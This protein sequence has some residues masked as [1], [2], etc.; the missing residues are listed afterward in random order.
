[1]AVGDLKPNE[2]HDPDKLTILGNHTFGQLIDYACTIFDSNHRTFVFMFVLMSDT[3][4]IARLDHD[5][6][7]FSDLIHWRTESYLADFFWRLAHFNAAERG[8]DTSAL[9]LAHDS[10]IT[11]Q[12]METARRCWAATVPSGIDID[13]VF[14][15]TKPLVM[16]RVWHDPQVGDD[17]SRMSKT[18]SS[19][20][21]AG[22]HHSLV[23]YKPRTPR[24][25]V[26]GRYTRGYIAVDLDEDQLVW[27]KDTWRISLDSIPEE[28]KTYRLLHT[29][30]V[31]RDFLPGFLFGGDVHV[32]PASADHVVQAS[33]TYHF[34]QKHP[35][36]VPGE[37]PKR[38]LSIEPH[39][40][41]RI[42]FKKIGRELHKFT[43]TKDLCQTVR[44]CLFGLCL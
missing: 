44:D 14:P 5:G 37:T 17:C 25:P 22:H 40:H 7:I 12:A 16:F 11:A 1:V 39:T 41:H 8:W 3:A 20:P 24:R 27:V 34:V 33:Q 2:T 19:L 10:P 9:P 28:S 31:T 38:A 18:P 23:T 42:V 36:M 30:G 13:D 32:D 4:R 35:E 6:V 26:I 43:K 29:S 21:V 15:S